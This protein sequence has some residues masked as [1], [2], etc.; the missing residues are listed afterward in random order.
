MTP[1]A[2]PHSRAR[3][4]AAVVPCKDEAQRIGATVTALRTVPRVELVVV[5]DDGSSD[6]TA[7]VA[8]AAGAEVVS[9]PRNRGKAAALMTGVSR[10]RAVAQAR[11]GPP[12]DYLFVD[13]DLADSAAALAPLLAPLAAGEADLVIATLPVQATPGG[14]RGLVVRLAREGIAALTGRVMTQPLSGMRALTDDAL[15]LA[16]PL[17]R[18]WGVEVGMTV[19]VL[20]AGLRIAEVRADLHHRV[21]GTDWR[22]QLHRARQYRD[23]WLALT[24]RGLRQVPFTAHPQRP[25][26]AVTGTNPP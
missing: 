25:R 16:S 22:A 9:H 10:V 11:G 14:G 2:R 4:V 23:V 3:P 15:T 6:D 19:D 17:A 21:T 1:P 13:G 7:E 8:R 20:R 18:G 26:P 5:V 24:A 12:P